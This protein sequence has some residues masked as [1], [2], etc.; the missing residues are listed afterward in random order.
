MT[1]YYGGSGNDTVSG[2]ILN[3]TMYGDAGNDS[4]NGGWLDDQLYGGTGDDTLLGDLGY[5]VLHG[6]AGN[7]LLYGGDDTYDD[8]YGGDGNDTL[9]AGNSSGD[10]SYGGA[11]DDLIFDGDGADM[12]RGGQGN[13]TLYGGYGDDTDVGGTGNDLIYGGHGSDSLAGD[14][15]HDTVDG[16]TEADTIQGGQGGDLLTGDDG[17]DLIH[18]DIRTFSPSAYASG[19][20]G[21]A[22]TFSLT[23]DSTLTLRLYW[24]DGTGTP[25]LYATLAPGQSWSGAT[26]SDSNFMLTDAATGDYLSVYVGGVNQSVTFTEDFADTIYG[27]QGADTIYGDYG[28]DLIDAGTENDLVYGGAGNDSLSGGA[29]NDTLAGD[30]GDD[31]LAGGAGADVFYGGTGL[32]VLDYSASGGAVLVNLQTGV[33]SGGDA[34]GDSLGSGIDGIIGSAHDDTLTGAD[35]QSTIPADR[36]TTWISAGAGNDL[37]KGGGGNDSLYG[38]AGNDTLYGGTGDDLLAGG[39]GDDSLLGNEG[40]DT[41]AVSESD[42]QDQILGGDEGGDTDILSLATT[43]AGGVTVTFQGWEWGSYSFGPGA[44]GGQFHEIEQIEGSAQADLID[45]TASGAALTLSGNAGND[46]LLGGG[47]DDLLSGGAGADLLAGGAGNDTLSGGTGQDLFG[48]TEGGGA[49]RIA[50]FDMTL[51]NG[52][53]ADQLD[54]SDLRNPDG[55]PLRWGDYTI[56]DDGQG[57]TLLSFPEG[58]SLVLVGVAPGGIGKLEAH[59]MGLPCFTAGTLIDT[60][61]GRRPVEALRAG[62]LVVTPQGAQP[63]LWAGGRRIDAAEL[64]ARPGLRPVLIR[65]GALGND[66]PLCLSRQHALLIEGAG[67][68]PALV[69]AGQLAQLGQG[70]FR[71]QAGRR[72]VAYHHLLLARHALV[73]ANGAWVETLW[74]GP[75]GLLALGPAA[76]AEIARA[77]PWLG[78]ALTAPALLPRLYGPRAAPHLSGRALR[79]LAAIRPADPRANLPDSPDP[80][81]RAALGF[82]I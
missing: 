46:T 38:D 47:G 23:N 75:A 28:N 42:G 39:A 12:A 29:G 43:L 40:S 77:L 18:G 5:D 72:H 8:L 82:G 56:A 24:I 70:A 16:G 49:D 3:D 67:G 30:A 79:G 71:V 25:Q 64:A 14:D 78:P 15:G 10:Y 36:Y 44:A 22:T 45:A 80:R 35:A 9:Y 37:V 50:D 2:T 20:A 51:S 68:Q 58:E 60:P 19:G 62:D 21:S 74:P 34:S 52:R 17:A 13:D 66:R 26:L 48:L 53:T 41:F 32:D 11:G 73:R 33:F 7:D 1:T 4:L 81:P 55:S 69:R 65:A 31:T 27:G 59:Q 6:D 57:N 76:R 54:A 61:Q 63:L